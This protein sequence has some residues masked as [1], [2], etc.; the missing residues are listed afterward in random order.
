MD[1][2]SPSH[3][4][5]Q[6]ADCE[7]PSNSFG[8]AGENIEIGVEGSRF[9]GRA[10]SGT[11]SASLTKAPCLM[12][13]PDLSPT[14]ST[15]SNIP[16]DVLTVVQDAS[17]VEKIDPPKSGTSKKDGAAEGMDYNEIN[18]EPSL[19]KDD[20]VRRDVGIVVEALES[21]LLLTRAIAAHTIDVVPGLDQETG[22]AGALAQFYAVGMI[23]TSTTLIGTAEHVL[24]AI[25]AKTKSMEVNLVVFA[26]IKVLAF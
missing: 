4:T 14:L 13:S 23:I 25:V 22:I 18:P 24:E 17:T 2:Y 5:D 6:D 20:I 12:K 19:L 26:K 15:L 16:S 7:I 9:F 3:P 10:V 11:G 21:V 8:N 1:V